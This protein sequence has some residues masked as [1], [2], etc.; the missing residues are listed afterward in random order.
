MA[1]FA[2]A[3]ARLLPGV[4]STPALRQKDVVPA[5]QVLPAHIAGKKL[6]TDWDSDK[7]IEY[8]FKS[9][10]YVY[11]A[12]RKIAESAASVPWY[13]AIQSRDGTWTPQPRHELTRLIEKPNP[14]LSRN[15]L[16]ERVISHLYLGGNGLIQKIT[17][18]RRL[19]GARLPAV[20]ELWPLQ[21]EGFSV[22][23]SKTRFIE[24]YEYSARGEKRSFTPEEIIHVAFMDPAN[25]YWGMSPL[26][27]AA[28]EVDVALQTISWN[29]HSMLN[30]AVSSGAFVSKEF[31]TDD[32]WE[33]ARQQV[34]EQH[35]GPENAWMPWV[36]GGGWTWQ[37][38]SM[39]PIE[40]DFVNSRQA[41]REEVLAA[42][43]VPPQIIGLASAPPDD[44][45]Y[46]QR[47]FW[48]ETVVPMMER[49]RLALQRALLPH[50]APEQRLELRY[51]L[52]AVEALHEDFEAEARTFYMLQRA[53]VPYQEAGRMV[54]FDLVDQGEIGTIPFGVVSAQMRLEGGGQA[55]QNKPGGQSAPNKPP[56]DDTQKPEDGQKPEAA[57]AGSGSTRD[58]QT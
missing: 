26:K 35:M 17:V 8:G 54:G 30:R 53:G 4:S 56:G 51:D 27:A 2:R 49:F 1:D 31:L 36:L 34:W 19:E 32:Q 28:R 23:P 29:M 39:S 33:E 44:T 57:A 38:M 12:I 14:Y 37:Q 5:P 43:G 55:T 48:T 40:M 41:N 13:A 20:V 25:P 7:A 18:S 24:S 50:F 22:V 16:F 11:L 58:N 47:M 15:E 9:C 3:L 10:V 42:F 6:F 46:Y 52:R 21:T 45:R